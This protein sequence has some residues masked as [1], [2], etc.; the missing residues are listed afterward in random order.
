MDKPLIA[1]LIHVRYR[2]EWVAGYVINVVK[3]DF[4]VRFF[5]TTI[6]EK[7]LKTTSF[8]TIEQRGWKLVKTPNTCQG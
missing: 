3:R 8:Q 5:D 7:W 4:L 1:D 6:P 2:G